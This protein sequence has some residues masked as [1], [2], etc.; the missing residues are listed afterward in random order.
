MGQWNRVYSSWKNAASRVCWAVTVASAFA[1]MQC[2]DKVAPTEPTA[3]VNPPSA[4]SAVSPA[5]AATVSAPAPP[6]TPPSA[7]ACAGRSIDEEMEQAAHLY[8]EGYV[9][10]ALS[11]VEK[12]LDCEQ[13]PRRVRIAALYA[14]VAKDLV[15]AKLYYKKLPP[16]MQSPIVQRCQHE[17]LDVRS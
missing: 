5:G 14:C 8:T 15:A 1:V 6:V 7:G 16:S 3:R 12:T 10:A 2:T 11:M 13:D 9:K 4:G 17:G